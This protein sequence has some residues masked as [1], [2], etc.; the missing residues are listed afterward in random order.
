MKDTNFLILNLIFNL[1]IFFY[2]FQ[3][4]KTSNFTFFLQNY[5]IFTYF[6]MIVFLFNFYYEYSFLKKPNETKFKK[7]EHRSNEMFEKL[8]FI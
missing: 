3:N 4:F 6:F 2:Y 7:I 8:A 1:N 5:Y